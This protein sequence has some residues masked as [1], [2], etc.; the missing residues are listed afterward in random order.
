MLHLVTHIK[1]TEGVSIALLKHDLM[2]NHDGYH[3]EPHVAGEM[4]LFEHKP[5]SSRSV[6]GHRQHDAVVSSCHEE[7]CVIYQIDVGHILSL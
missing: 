2:E 6:S 5:V 7:V 3:R 4:I 1:A